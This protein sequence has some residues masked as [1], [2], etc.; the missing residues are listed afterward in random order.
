MASDIDPVESRDVRGAI[1]L[2]RELRSAARHL[3]E[4]EIGGNELFMDI[5]KEVVAWEQAVKS[6]SGQAR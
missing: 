3:T 2:L 4:A 5:I 6:R 1:G